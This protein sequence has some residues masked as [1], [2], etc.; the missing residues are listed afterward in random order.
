ML[1]H[2]NDTLKTWPFVVAQWDQNLHTLGGLCITLLKNHVLHGILL[3]PD[4]H[5]VGVATSQ[6]QCIAMGLTML[7]RSAQRHRILELG[8]RLGLL[9]EKLRHPVYIQQFIARHCVPLELWDIMH[10][11]IHD[12]STERHRRYALPSV[13]AL[14]KWKLDEWLNYYVW[15]NIITF[16]LHPLKPLARTVGRCLTLMVKECIKAMLFIALPF[17]LGVRDICMGL[18][19]LDAK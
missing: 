17:L 10:F 6:S 7:L 1:T 19:T 18:V 4:F 16:A 12:T 14:P 2:V 3:A 13:F 15:R 11:K 8:N 9:S 5:I